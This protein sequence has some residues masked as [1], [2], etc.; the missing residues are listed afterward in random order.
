MLQS[1]VWWAQAHRET[2][3]PSQRQKPA[4]SCRNHVLVSC[5][6]KTSSVR[7]NQTR[8]PGRQ[9]QSEC[10]DCQQ[11]WSCP[12]FSLSRNVFL[13][14][15]LL[16][17]DKVLPWVYSRTQG[18]AKVVRQPLPFKSAIAP[19]DETIWR[20]FHI[21]KMLLWHVI[22]YFPQQISESGL[23]S[24]GHRT[25]GRKMRAKRP[26][27]SVVV[28]L[29]IPG[30]HHLHHQCHRHR[31]HFHLWSATEKQMAWLLPIRNL[32]SRNLRLFIQSH[33]RSIMPVFCKLLLSTYCI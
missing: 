20:V 31:H 5:H 9:C 2:S 19:R 33:I 30:Y 14:W 21:C 11:F 16:A 29:I 8:C 23:L 6:K 27:D 24:R 26:A 12:C 18:F 28:I 17:D 10:H 22:I 4:L 1:P 7:R 15:N 3:T 32:I 13:L 25:S